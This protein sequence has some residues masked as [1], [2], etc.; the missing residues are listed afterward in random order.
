MRR[1]N[2]D[3]LAIF[4]C[5]V[6]TGGFRRAAAELGTSTSNLSHAIKQLERRLGLRLLN[7]TSRSVA[8]TEAG[9][10]LLATLDPALRSIDGALDAIALGS[11]TI[12][13]TLRITATREGYDAVIR[14][15]LPAFARAHPLATIE[16]L[17]EYG[18]RDIVAD[19]FDAGIRLG[20]KLQQDMIAVKLGPDLRMAVVAAPSYVA[21]HGGPAEP[22]DLVDHR[23]I[24]YRMVAAGSL[25]AWE[26][27]RDGHPV[28]MRVEGPLT[29][30]QP[31]L[32]LDAALEGLGIGYVLEETAAPFVADGR[33]LRFL[34]D[35][36]P[37][38]PGFYLYHSSRHQVRPVLAAFIA[39]AR[40]AASLR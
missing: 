4:S 40:E 35:W 8:P 10:Q 24:N 18:F 17:I 9:V 16:V 12:S 30:N 20:E 1:G 19:R 23:C 29:F 7:R 6:R 37:A 3:D 28:E 31:E 22:R 25:Y 39:T 2:L 14:P 38:F 27:E 21:A 5:I 26:F 33:L 36:T 34:A 32:M 13:G 15:A 11:N